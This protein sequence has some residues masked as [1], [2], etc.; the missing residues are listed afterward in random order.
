MEITKTT[1][2]ALLGA[3]TFWVPD[4]AIQAVEGK[5]FARAGVAAAT[6]LMLAAATSAFMW[7][8]KMGLK[9][10]VGWSRAL[11]MLLGIWI[12][13]PWFMMA[14]YTFA[15]A[16]FATMSARDLIFLFIPG[17]AFIM[18]GYD[19]SLGALLIITVVLPVIMCFRSSKRRTHQGTA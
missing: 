16:G 4:L 19:G 3:L 17:V 7:F 15:G 14:A 5:D 13:G 12:L 1:Q 8:D 18:A 2:T 10:L 9:T 6:L 11:A